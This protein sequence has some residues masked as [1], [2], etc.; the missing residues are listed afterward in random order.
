MALSPIKALFFA[1]TWA[2]WV[3][4][5]GEVDQEIQEI[6]ECSGWDILTGCGAT[7]S[8]LFQV[9]ALGTV[10]GAPALVNVPFTILGLASRATVMWSLLELFRGT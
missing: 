8:Y 10:P 7:A 1:I 5:W 9:A 4:A 2:F 3:A 6:P